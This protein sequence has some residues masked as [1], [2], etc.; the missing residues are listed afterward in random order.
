MTLYHSAIADILIQ[1]NKNAPEKVII[2]EGSLKVAAGEIYRDAI[3]I[4]LNLKK[5][6]FNTHDRVA[7]AAPPNAEFVKIMYALIFLKATVAIIDPE[8]GRDNYNSKLKQFNPQWTFVDSRLLLLQEHPILRYFYLKKSKTTP[9]FPYTPSA[10]TIACGI[11][12]PL[13]QKKTFLKSMINKPLN[14]DFNWAINGELINDFNG[15]LNADLIQKNKKELIK[16][17]ELINDF[18]SELINENNDNLIENK[19]KNSVY[20]EGSSDFLI[21]YTSGTI[22][23][24]KGVVHSFNSLLNSLNLIGQ[25]LNPEKETL[26]AT[27]LPHYMLIGF[28]VKIP[29]ILYNPKLNPVEKLAFFKAN[30]VTTIMGPPSDFVPMIEHCEATKTQFPD[31]MQHLLLGS[32]PVTRRFLRRLSDVLPSHTRITCLYGMTENLLSAT[33]DGRFKMDYDCEGDL[34]GKPAEGVE[35]N[36]VDDEIV[37]KSNQLFS[38][39]FH[40]KSRNDCH[41]TGDLGAFDKNNLLILRGRKKDMIIRRNLN[42]YPAIYESTINRI[43]GVTEAVLVG[44]YD[45]LIHDEKVYLIVEGADFLNKKDILNQLKTGIYSIDNEAMPDDILFMQLPRSGRQHKVN[46]AAIRDL[47][48]LK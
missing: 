42:I 36:I 12:L 35:I 24:P 2:T 16:N 46:K 8:M 21:T 5:R 37:L 15:E 41:E 9:Y 11:W 14:N 13:L 38:R 17:N 39:Y 22:A 23:E 3:K 19:D 32:A 18:N 6:G 29:S 30:N 43:N 1:L 33:I 28:S 31:S 10:K 45:D 25:L 26:I 7:I 47:I 44:V 27:Y 4:A 48:K 40:L 20:T 34:L